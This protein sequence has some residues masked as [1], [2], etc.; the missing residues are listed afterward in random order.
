MSNFDRETQE[1]LD[2]GLNL[3]L[4]YWFHDNEYEHCKIHWNHIGNPDSGVYVDMGS[5]IGTF[6]YNI[7]KLMPNLKIYNVTNSLFQH[8]YQLN[9]F[10]STDSKSLESKHE[11]FTKTS[12]GDNSVDII[13][14][15]ESFGYE[16]LNETFAEVSRILK[17]GGKLFIKECFVL[18]NKP[19]IIYEWEKIWN[20]VWYPADE[21]ILG[22]QNHNL[23]FDKCIRVP[24]SAEK[25]LKFWKASAKMQQWFGPPAE[26]PLR[27]EVG[28]FCFSKI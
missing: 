7:S 9:L 27:Q 28:I 13:T 16:N 20:Y 23:N 10:Q 18:K 8:R 21:I 12:F 6:G 17:P 1:Y 14:F 4:S 3:L 26:L 5:G 11:S 2:H 22:G 19:Q 24:A 25:F 15:N